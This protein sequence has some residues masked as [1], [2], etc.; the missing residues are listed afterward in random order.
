MNHRSIGNTHE[1]KIPNV[2]TV[3][4]VFGGPAVMPYG[5]FVPQI[6]PTTW[7]VRSPSPSFIEV[8]LE[9]DKDEEAPEDATTCVICI[10]SLPLCAA[11]PCG[12]KCLCCKCAREL[13]KDGTAEQGSVQCPVCREKINLIK[14]IY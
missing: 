10:T 1:W 8:P 14:R 11:L 13:G 5:T 9:T 4:P 6:Q 12:H 3:N 2:Y 7:T